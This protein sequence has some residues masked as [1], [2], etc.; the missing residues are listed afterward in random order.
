MPGT[1]TSTP[2]TSLH[3]AFGADSIPRMRQHRIG[4]RAPLT[5][6]FQVDQQGRISAENLLAARDSHAPERRDRATATSRPTS[7]REARRA[8]YDLDTIGNIKQAPHEALDAGARRRQAE[9]P[10]RARQRDRQRTTTDRQPASVAQRDPVQFSFDQFTG[11]VLRRPARA[12]AAKSTF[13]YDALDRRRG[14]HR[15]SDNSDQLYVWDGNQ[16]VAHGTANDLT[17]DVPGDD[18]D[19]HIV[20]IDQFGTGSQWFYHQGPDQSTLA[21]TGSAG[22]VEAYTYSAFGELLD[23]E[24]HRPSRRPQSA[25]GNI[26]QFQ[27]QVFDAATGD[28]LDAR[29]PISAGLGHVPLARSDRIPAAVRAYTRSREAGLSQREIRLGL[30]PRESNAEWAREWM[31]SWDSPFAAPWAS[32]FLAAESELPD[33]QSRDSDYYYYDQDGQL[34][35]RQYLGGW[36]DVNSGYSFRDGASDRESSSSEGSYLEHYRDTVIAEGYIDPSTPPSAAPVQ[37]YASFD[38]ALAAAGERYRQRMAEEADPLHLGE[39]FSSLNKELIE[40]LAVVPFVAGGLAVVEEGEALAEAASGGLAPVRQGA[41]GV[42]RAVA[43]L[44]AAGGRVLGREITIDAGGVRTRPDLFVELPSGQQAFLEIKTGAS[45][46][47]TPNQTAAFPQIWTQG[48]IPCGANAAAAGL[49]PRVPIGPT[50]V[51]TVHYPWPLP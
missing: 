31:A 35:D 46:G 38:A 32:E 30:E 47:L 29:P 1:T 14:E 40:P 21:V 3:E 28:L 9:P 8:A 4:A 2:V 48:G 11:T 27:G 17:L 13:T 24:P 16:L 36:N 51:W 19:A 37:H 33:L 34:H 5:D 43:D 44:E 6:V 25:F 20:S 15:S 22:L 49:T 45:A 10:D 39:F 12:A 26:F 41:A 50:T 42:E 7:T 18:I 23:L